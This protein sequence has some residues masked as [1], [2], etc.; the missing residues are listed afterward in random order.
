MSERSGQ[1]TKAKDG[2]TKYAT[3]NLFNTY[4]GK[5]IETQK[6][7]VAAR[8]GL[9]SLGKVA[10]SRR[11][12]PPANLPSLK[13]ENK[14]NDP[15]VNIVPKDGSGWVT[16]S[17]QQ[18]E[19][20]IATEVQVQE[21]PQPSSDPPA[22]KA[23]EAPVVKTW[24]QTNNKHTGQGDG[25]Q[26]L[27]SHFQHEF[28]SLQAAGDQDKTVKELPDETFGS[29]PSLRPQYVATW[30]DAGGKT[31]MEQDGKPTNLEDGGTRMPM[32]ELNDGFRGLDKRDI[33]EKTSLP[34]TKINGQLVISAAPQFR[35][36]MTPYMSY[37]PAKMQGSYRL[38]YPA[39]NTK[40][41]A[42]ARPGNTQWAL[43]LLERPSIIN[44]NDLKEL[45]N[46]DTEADDGW[47]GAQSEVDYT[48][49]L[50]FSDEDEG[51]STEGKNEKR[52]EQ[53]A[54]AESLGSR[55]ES[56]DVR[57]ETECPVGKDTAVERATLQTAPLSPNNS[58]PNRDPQSDRQEFGRTSLQTAAR[59]LR[60]LGNVSV[61]QKPASQHLPPSRQIGPGKHPIKPLLPCDGDEAW[62]QR[63]KASNSD[64]S[65]AVERARKRREEEER[66]MEEQR[67]AACAAKL[68]KLDEKFG[69]QEKKA[70]ENEKEKAKM[71][72]KVQPE[73]EIK[74]EQQKEQEKEQQKET[75][76]EQEK[77]KEQLEESAKIENHQQ[78]EEELSEVN[79]EKKEVE[80]EQP[81]EK[82]KARQQETEE[83]KDCPQEKE[84]NTNEGEGE[85]EVEKI[86]EEPC[87]ESVFKDQQTENESSTQ[88]ESDGVSLPI[89][90]LD[91]PLNE[92]EITQ[93]PNDADV[94][95]ASQS[96]PAA[97]TGYSKQFQKSLPPRF[98]R[99][100]EQ[101]KQQQHQWQQQPSGIHQQT[102][103]QTPAQSQTQT[104][105][106]PQPSGASVPPPPQHRPIYQTPLAPHH[107]H[108]ASMGF[109]P[110][111]IMMQ[112]YL[113]P[114]IISGRPPMDMTQIHPGMI[115][116]KLMRRDQIDSSG[117]G[118]ETFDHPSRPTRDH[119]IQ[120]AEPQLVWGS[121]S[122]PHTEPQRTTTPTVVV[123][124]SKDL[125][126]EVVAEQ[127]RKLHAY[128]TEKRQLSPHLNQELFRDKTNDEKGKFT[129]KSLEDEQS[130][131]VENMGDPGNLEP[132]DSGVIRG[133][134][135]EPILRGETR[136]VLKRNLSHGSNH[137]L[138]LEDQKTDS[139]PN[140]IKIQNR[141]MESKDHI[142]KPDEKAKKESR[143]LEV[144]KT[145]KPFRRESRY[146]TRWGP[147]PGSR[148]DEGHMRPVR[149]SGP[150]KKP[151]LRDMKEEREQRKEKEERHSI[152]IKGNKT[153]KTERREP[154]QA[155]K[156][157]VKPEAE[158][159]PLDTSSS[160]IKKAGQDLKP[161]I[162]KTETPS[163]ITSVGKTNNNQA[164]SNQTSKDEKQEKAHVKNQVSDKQHIENR[165]SAR[166]DSG[167]PPRNYRK[168]IREQRDW[169]PEQVYRGRGC[170]EFYSRGHSFRGSYSGRGRGGRGRS[171]EYPRYRESRQRSENV[172]NVSSFRQREESE[173]RSES[174]DFEEV[175][176]RRRQHGSETDSDTEA[177]ESASETISDKENPPK[178][179]CLK[180][181]GRP[182]SKPV[183]KSFRSESTLKVDNRSSEKPV[184]KD[185]DSKPKPGFLPRGE[186]SRRGRGGM[187]RGGG[188]GTGGRGGSRSA[189]LRKSGPSNS[190]WSPRLEPS[191]RDDGE[192]KKDHF[193]P[194][195][196]DKRPVKSERKFDHNR[197]QLRKQR[198]TRPPRQDKP[199]RFRRL[200]ER[201]AAAKVNEH[202]ATINTNSNSNVQEH[203]TSLD[204]AGSKSPD[205]SNQNSSDQAN[206]EWETASESSDFNERRERDEKKITD[207]NLQATKSGESNFL[208]KRD[209]A[210]R[211]FSSQRPGTDRQNRRS[212]SG[213]NKSNRNYSANKNERRSGLSSKTGRRGPLEERTAMIGIDPTSSN[214]AHHPAE[215]S[216]TGTSLKSTKEATGKKRE[217]SKSAKKTKEKPDA[218]S[219]FDLNNYA[220]VVIIDDHPEVTT[221][222][223]SQCNTIDDGFT[224]VVSK[225]QQKRLQDE[226]RR[227]KEEQVVQN[228][229]KKNS[230]EKGRGQN[231]KLPPRFAKKQQQ[232]AQQTQA[233]AP[234]SV[235]PQAQPQQQPVVSTTDSVQ[236]SAQG[237]SSV[238]TP[239]SVPEQSKVQGGS[240]TSGNNSECSLS[241][242]AQTHSTLDT[243]LWDNQISSSGVLSD[244]TTKL[245]SISPPQPPSVSAWNKP[246]TSFGSSSS[247]EGTVSS[248]EAGIEL[249]IEAG[250]VNK[251]S[252]TPAATTT[253]TDVEAESDVSTTE[254]AAELKLPEPKEQRQKQSRAG[255][256]KAQKLPELNLMENK[257]HKPGPIGKERSLKNRKAKD[258]QQPETEGKDDPPAATVGGPEPVITQESNVVTELST[259]VKTMISV[260]TTEF[261]ENSK[262]SMTDYTAPSSSLPD[263]VSSGN[264]KIEDSLA[265]NVPLPHTLPIPRRETLQ[266][267]SN[268]TPVSPATVDF[269]LKME[270]ARKAWEN[271]PN[272]GDKSSPVTSTASPI[273][274]SNGGSSSTYSSFSSASMPPIPVASVTPTTSLSGSGTYTTSSLSTKATSTSDPPNIC[275][276]KPQQL[277]TSN[278]AP[279]SHFSQIGCVTSLLPQQQQNPQVYVSQS[280]AEPAAQIP[281]FYMDT[282]H[283]FNTQHP[284]L[285]PPTLAQQQG[286]QAG[287]S[288]PTAVQQISIPI[289]A[290]I[291]GQPQ[292]QLSLGGGPSVSQAQEM[293]ST[294]LQPF[295]TQQAF[296][297]NNLSQPSPVVLSGTALHNFPAVQAQDL[298]KAQSGLAF[299][300]TSNAQPIPI[301][302]EHTLSQGSGLGG[303][304]LLDTHLIQGNSNQWHVQGLR[305]GEADAGNYNICYQTFQHFHRK[306]RPGLTQPSNLFTGQVQQPG[307]SNYYSTAQSPNA[308]L[309]QVTLPLPGSQL[310]L[311]NFGSAG[312][313]LI[314]LP[315]SMQPLQHN[316]AQAQPHNLSRPTQINQPFRGLIA[317][318]TQAGMISA[319]GKMA[320]MDLK[321]YGCSVD[322]K[323][324]TPPISVR[325]ITP[326]SSP[327]RASS[328]SPN[329]QSSKINNMV[330]QKQFSSAGVRIAQPFPPQFPPQ[331]LSQPNLVPPLVRPHGNTFSAPVQ[332]PPLPLTNQMQSQMTTGIICQ[333]RPQHT[334]RV[335]SGHTQGIRGNQAQAAMMAEQDLKAKQ[336]A[337][338]LQ[339]T[340]KFFSD[341]QQ[342]QI[343]QQV[344]KPHKND[345]S[346]N[347]PTESGTGISSTRE[348]KVEEKPA[349]SQAVV[350]KPV[351]TGPIKPQAVKT[352]ETKS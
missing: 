138:K 85:G 29:G 89:D 157:V 150:I 305:T 216:N 347:K 197:E 287:P 223:D 159:S 193:E 84:E 333:T 210:K 22:S 153:A 181:E 229:N 165:F 9:Q 113:D 258:V 238:E 143:T 328:T 341:Q 279:A 278:M 243:E 77:A 20:S 234:A 219:Q 139:V 212:N 114:R 269:T 115:P 125:R 36:I 135:E 112:P 190:I 296:L 233:Q 301:L 35:G 34:V 149:R 253:T 167:L 182:D 264:S 292:A 27:N 176:K 39:P 40:N 321:P 270:C 116:T 43:D 6:N 191:R 164:V 309:Q 242:P 320:E 331:M 245:A 227:K 75:I 32:P 263:S 88:T 16:K 145:E 136:T 14:G 262:E 322:V 236:D 329:S 346:G 228:W 275:K 155:N 55:T 59:D 123:E 69:I 73:K 198:P 23:P 291:P 324:G 174:S 303:S 87:N 247:P 41:Q 221:I 250:Q 161:S 81:L 76:K 206:E 230:N 31:V 103:S 231:S 251:S 352:E 130:V 316:P 127:E 185:V 241:A 47:A 338:V 118:S 180:K 110:R 63:R 24:A 171:R 86:M 17:E 343:K 267:S 284:R 57:K 326:S 101:M 98:Q 80:K 276:V 194:L 311:P 48:E 271:S 342:Q 15:N 38:P 44:A 348:E 319:P 214:V 334:P 232:A 60:G 58:S 54:K 90:Q 96:R 148:R 298:A 183:Q 79:E 299:Q 131:Q 318:G 260:P 26:S 140:T 146:D 351:R 91:S 350:S 209:A 104:Q 53:I 196:F 170:G 49:K 133:S 226:E 202:T 256:I 277:Q 274:S 8:H 306:A 327:F 147:R 50:N 120:S 184:S 289:Y 339:S 186:P 344:S 156:V 62:R 45:D 7:A 13:A 273:S 308:A 12:P 51:G 93:T 160:V 144:V 82:E 349:S 307:Q 310:S 337:E 70:K 173:T 218:L 239:V 142:D 293:F 3:L 132:V 240:C 92:K 30:R 335:P 65:A 129:N 192:T 200:K 33:R 141:V 106:K 162:D 56:P 208:P 11:I 119:T 126:S 265:S 312:Q 304:Q 235:Q 330:Y 108:L 68:K 2:K 213:A 42:S 281:T 205:L 163:T 122:Y 302:Y 336:R 300:Q 74:E 134:Q 151:V 217:E 25:I 18:E 203:P 195:P 272:V 178:G 72:E 317:T 252:C 154:S 257:E 261:E 137:S 61:N 168:E 71:K 297:Q 117:S 332:R 83:A 199:P 248:P 28:P 107:Q 222:E 111:W 1:S 97:P 179:K 177:H 188:R 323:P 46:L 285:A 189:S 128:S 64:V 158:K 266:Q 295:R 204:L 290:P 169:F 224:E 340:H 282:S 244:I 207:I 121:E 10:S 225:K 124:E 5:S 166:R 288:Q 175:P 314:A 19:S 220:S 4:K 315:Q 280:A 66:R 78:K 21:P 325:S 37:P 94:D 95:L 254:K 249:T 215:N 187:Y 345:S 286:F 100:Q 255:P 211:S 246:L 67:L 102:Q 99:Q 105:A 201:E 109:D 283:L 172:S 237:P 268:L 52:A 152:P 313:P 259:E 294:S